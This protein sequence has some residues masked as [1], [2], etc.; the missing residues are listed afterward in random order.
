MKNKKAQLAHILVILVSMA[1]IFVVLLKFYGAIIALIRGIG[2]DY[3]FCLL[4]KVI[5]AYTKVPIIG[6]STWG[7]FCPPVI[8]TIT[9]T[10]KGD[11]L[12]PIQVPLSK[13]EISNLDKWY[14]DKG[15][16]FGDKEWQDTTEGIDW[17]LK[18]RL[19]QAVTQG[20]KRCWGRNGQGRLPLGSEWADKD[21][22]YK[23]IAKQEIF[24][25]DLCA[26]YQFR[27]KVKRINVQDRPLDE[28][29]KRHPIGSISTWEYLKDDQYTDLKTR[30]YSANRD[31][32]IVYIRSNPNNLH[33]LAW[34]VLRI[35]PGIGKEDV[36]DPYD[37]VI[38]PSFEKFETLGCTT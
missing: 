2:E 14:K 37:A 9:L 18:Y 12:I 32:A 36:P 6:V 22:F 7:A 13:R 35:L 17:L 28:Y 16:N 10:A 20:M 5:S 15:I 19:D 4:K 33:L 25:C 31:L 29:L 38:L 34:E 11:D 23:T 24:Y 1:I 3:F 26:V 21:G 8:K 30:K 27:D